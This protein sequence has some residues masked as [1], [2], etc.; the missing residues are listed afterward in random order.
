M[1]DI[2]GASYVSYCRVVVRGLTEIR[3]ARSW[4]SYALPLFTPSY[5]RST[6]Y[7]KF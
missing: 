7:D 1:V 5:P 4:F 2:R 6:L 3:V